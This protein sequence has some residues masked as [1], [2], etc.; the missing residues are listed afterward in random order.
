MTKVTRRCF[1]GEVRSNTRLPVA[2][3]SGDQPGQAPT[4]SRRVSEADVT[5]QARSP[6]PNASSLVPWQRAMLLA[7]LHHEEVDNISLHEVVSPTT[8][9]RLSSVPLIPLRARMNR[10]ANIAPIAEALLHTV[11]RLTALSLLW[12]AHRVLRSAF[13]LYLRHLM[14]AG[15]TRVVLS[16]TRALER[17]AVTIMFGS[18]SR[19]RTRARQRENS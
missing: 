1:Q 16:V 4:Q 12:L 5:K 14:T 13:R 18:C 7:S 11:R 6:V 10:L 3:N 15:G 2:S 19:R 17:A 8:I 9:N